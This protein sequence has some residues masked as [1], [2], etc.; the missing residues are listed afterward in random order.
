MLEFIPDISPAMCLCQ[1]LV[2]ICHQIA[3][4]RELFSQCAQSA[5]IESCPDYEM[6]AIISCSN[7]V[8][9]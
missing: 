9:N 8:T 1:D 7:I 6:D 2:S 5:M 4:N 3:T